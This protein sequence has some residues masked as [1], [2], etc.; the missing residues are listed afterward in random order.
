MRNHAIKD[1]LRDILTSAL[2][3]RMIGMRYGK[4]KTTIG[5]CRRR[6]QERGIL[7]PAIKDLAISEVDEKLREKINTVEEQKVVKA[8]RV[9]DFAD[10]DQALQH[11]GMT[12][13]CYWEE[14]RAVNAATV[15]YSRL[16]T[17][18][19]EH[20]KKK[21]KVMRLRHIPGERCQV[22]YSGEKPWY[23][24]AKGEKVVVEMFVG[25]LPASGRVYAECTPSQKIPDWCASHVRML[26]AF[27]GSPKVF[28][29]DNLRSGVTRAGADPTI[30]RTYRELAEHYGV[31]VLP[32]RPRS[33]KDKAR[34]EFSVLL[35]QRAF[36][37]ILR[38]RRFT[39]LDD[40]NAALAVRVQQVN[41]RRFQKW[42]DSR[43]ERF[44]RIEKHT[45][46][47]LPTEPFS[48]VTWTAAQ[49]VP[50]DYHVRVHDHLYSVP[51]RLVGERVEARVSAET[52]ELYS[53]GVL[54][55]KHALSTVQ[56]AH[57]TDPAHQAPEHRAMEG[58]TQEALGD[59]AASVG[60]ATAEVVR[61]LFD[62]KVPLQ[63][64]PSVVQLKNLG[65]ARGMGALERAAGRAVELNA[66]SV[67]G[68]ERLLKASA[69]SGSGPGALRP[70]SSLSRS[71][72][73][74]NRPVTEG[75]AS[76][77]PVHGRSQRQRPTAA[78][79]ARKSSR[80]EGSHEKR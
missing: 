75:H 39:S 46:Q 30:N 26:A 1:I 37:P 64:M 18:Y 66:C 76:L 29:P 49:V 59:W 54:V 9:P 17:L 44:E 50:T 53:D 45:L 25:A 61:R 32:A 15:S 67:S 58:R 52:V 56:A 47:P 4:S 2:S 12:L 23:F 34:A 28:V 40:L 43:M 72:G 68:I 10:I 24:N 79:R 55:A 8:P 38:H 36:L 73:A 14:A 16:A 21:P 69:A 74:A 11:P 77:R 42:P 65:L 62:R 48:Y 57:T 19:R 13:W 51:C 3:D 7:W 31:A 27:G 70:Q 20:C 6:A 35:M 80:K 41:A 63:G 5:T 22:D 33:P 71:E 60:P 78:P